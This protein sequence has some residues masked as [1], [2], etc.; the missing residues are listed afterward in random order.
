MQ[1]LRGRRDDEPALAGAVAR[2]GWS[3]SLR[4]LVE[5]YRVDAVQMHDMDFFISE[6]RVAEFAERIAPLGINWWALG[7]ID[8]L[9]QYSD[10]TWQ[11]MAAVGPEDGVLGRRVGVRR[12]RWPR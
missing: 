12:R 4:H 2:R 7:R 6:A 10:A 5:T 11:A 1:F 9:M 8:T 3:G